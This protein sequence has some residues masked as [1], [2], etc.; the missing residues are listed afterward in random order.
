[1][2]R[3]CRENEYM[4]II[5]RRLNCNEQYSINLG[6]INVKPDLS[7][8]GTAYEVECE[9]KVHYGVG[10]A[11]AYQYG[12]LR[13]GLIVITT[14]EDNNKLSQLMNFLRWARNKLGIETYIFRCIQ[15]DCDLL[16]IE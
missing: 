14:D 12:G 3:Q 1:M 2:V 10:Q 13:A 9:D 11:I 6:F 8:N 4:A 16:K 5:A 7:C 15:Y